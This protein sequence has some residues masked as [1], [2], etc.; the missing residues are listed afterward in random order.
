MN[1]FIQGAQALATTIQ[2][3]K[4]SLIFTAKLL[5]NYDIVALQYVI[6]N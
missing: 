5:V 6:N 4:A 1:I 2:G 3:K